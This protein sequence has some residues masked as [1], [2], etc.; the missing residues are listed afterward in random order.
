MPHPGGR[1][2]EPA[3]PAPHQPGG[4]G[5][6][7]P[8]TGRLRSPEP[9]GHPSQVSMGER[10]EAAAPGPWGLPRPS[11][12]LPTGHSGT[13]STGLWSGPLVPRQLHPERLCAPD[14]RLRS[15]W[16]SVD[17]GLWGPGEL[18]CPRGVPEASPRLPGGLSTEGTEVRAQEPERG[19][20]GLG[21]P[22]VPSQPPRPRGPRGSSPSRPSPGFPEVPPSHPWATVLESA[23]AQESRSSLT[24]APNETPSEG[25]VGRAQRMVPGPAGHRGLESGAGAGPPCCTCSLGPA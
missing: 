20:A 9:H 16:E 21:W 10:R 23:S 11:L 14:C 6:C 18:W 5:P 8:C 25:H 15:G 13:C 19:P 12:R 24:V 2:W 7:G 3:G 22:S 17:S 1:L 4:H